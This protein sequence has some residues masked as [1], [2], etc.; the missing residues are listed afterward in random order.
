[1]TDRYMTHTELRRLA[2]PY[3][4]ADSPPHGPTLVWGYGDIRE[5]DATGL[6]HLHR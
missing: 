4:R 1:M 2:R 5:F 3:V 6:T